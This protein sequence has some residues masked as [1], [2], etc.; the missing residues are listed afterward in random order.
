[1]AERPL[2][3]QA[4]AGAYSDYVVRP[5][6]DRE[7]LRRTLAA[8][9]SY[10]AYALG[11]LQPHLFARS[12]WWVSRGAQGQALVLHSQG[13][14]GNALFALGTADALDATLRIHPGPRHTFLTCQEH[15][16]HV[17]LRHYRLAVPESMLRMIVIGDT[18]RPVEG[19]ARQLSGRDVRDIN[20]LYRADGTPAFYS[21]ENIDDAIYY[22][23]FD[24]D[25]LVA[26][27]GTHV[28]SAGDGIGVVGNVFTRPAYRNQGL[29][30]VV[31]TAV[32]RRLLDNCRDVVLSVDPRNAPAVQTY[33]KLGFRDAGR[34]I[35][36]PAVRRGLGVAAWLRRRVAGIR[37][38]RFGAE[39]VKVQAEG[40][41]RER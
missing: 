33:R 16:R 4:V 11:Q 22:G 17:V 30:A 3:R 19:R 31:T 37:G 21:A 39:F 27:A 8:H 18:F 36:G 26:V 28:V 7:E 13:G 9:R 15:H 1:M 24:G 20:K 5:E 32:T 29:G 10:S 40:E 38:G 35:E 23:A 14:L 41:Q 12:E 6:R 25:Q 2:S 34:L